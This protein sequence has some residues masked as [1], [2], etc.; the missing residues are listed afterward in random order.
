MK[1]LL[2]T[3]VFLWCI[4]GK[5][6]RVSARASKIVEDDDTKLLLSVASLWEIALKVRTGKL[7]L[8]ETADFF[9][10]HMALLGIDAV[11]AIEARHVF[12]LFGLPDHHRDPFDRLLAAQ[13]VAEKLPLIASDPMLRRYPIEVIW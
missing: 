10:R 5:K 8:P 3:N 11:L 12:A 1:A 9:H 4:G 6:S 7:E 13:C 2:D